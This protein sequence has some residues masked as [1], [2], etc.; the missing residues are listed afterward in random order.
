MPLSFPSSPALNELYTYNSVTWQ[1]NGTGWYIVKAIPTGPTGPTGSQGTGLIISGSYNSIE[2]LN[3]DHP[4][5]PDFDGQSFLINGSLYVWSTDTSSW[6][7][8]GNIAGPT[9]PLGPTGPR[10]ITGPTGTTGPT[11]TVPGPTGP[12]GARGESGA[13]IVLKGSVPAAENLPVSGNLVNDAYIVDSDGNIYIWD[14]NSWNDAGQIVGPTGVTGPTG[15][16]G[17]FTLESSTPPSG[18][19]YGDAWF[20]SN[21]GKVYVFYDDY[22]VEVGASQIGPTGPQ[23]IQGITGPTG[24][25]GADALWEYLGEYNGGVLY[26]VGAVVTYNGQLWYRNVYTS[27]GYVPGVDN[28]YWDLLAASGEHGATGPGFGITY[29]GDYNPLSGYVTDIAVAR[30]SD[31]QLYL[32]KAS[33]QLGDPINYLSNGQWEVWIPNGATGATGATGLT[34]A[35]GPTGEQGLTGLQ[36]VQGIEGPTGPQGIT[37]PTGAQGATGA[38]GATGIRGL[39]GPIGITGPT[40]PLGPTGAQGIQGVTGPTGSQGDSITGPTG[41][42]GIQ[43]ITGPQGP[44]G[45]TGIQGDSITGPTGVQGITGPTGPQGI[46]GNDGPTGPQGQ[47]L[48]ISG[49]YATYAALV[50]AHPSGYPGEAYIVTGD[51]YIWDAV[52]IQWQNTGRFQ[53]PT[54]PQGEQGVQGLTGPTGEQGATG[55]TGSFNTEA[56]QTYNPVW[57]ASTTNPTIGNGTL[58]GKYLIMGRLVFS[59]I[60][61]IAGSTTDRGSG[62]YRVSLPFTGAVGSRNLEPVGQVVMRSISLGK[63]F[64]GTCVFNN[65][66]RTR[67]ELFIHSQVSVFDE[68]SGATHIEPF[69]FQTNDEILIELMYERAV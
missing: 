12:T 57:T 49:S 4:I 18:A 45:A 3:S 11:S 5:G 1:W 44:T 19:L 64:F 33:G 24:S 35:T 65:D 54:G 26:G 58:A 31:G 16:Y 36:G 7:N 43:G 69:L 15:R 37:G 32:A 47:G 10:G 38:T 46:Q 63:S 40:G 34:G 61:I 48:F 30:G 25:A 29:T 39:T 42:T 55:P 8:V 20:N 27:A 59:S 66:D 60:K 21:N 28:A 13:S 50:A 9:G 14:G 23:G 62:T 68:G 6:T 22:W 53:G 17:Q 52:G 41:A 51:L 67:I 56:L 2:D